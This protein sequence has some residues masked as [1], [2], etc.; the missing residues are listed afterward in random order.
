MI[1]FRVSESQSL[2]VSE[3]FSLEL[4]NMSQT[5]TCDK[6]RFLHSDFCKVADEQNKNLCIELENSI[7]KNECPKCPSDNPQRGT[8][9]I[10]P[11]AGCGIGIFIAKE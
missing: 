10:K 1:F 4:E 7:N 9:Q 6:L 11:V 3:S 8:K 5:E 2:R